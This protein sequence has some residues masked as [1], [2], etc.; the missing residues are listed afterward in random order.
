MFYSPVVT[1]MFQTGNKFVDWQ[2]PNLAIWLE[3]A[4]I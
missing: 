3:M 1:Y 2:Q 4:E